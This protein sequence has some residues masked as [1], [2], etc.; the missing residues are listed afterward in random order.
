MV[1][2]YGRGREFLELDLCT[3]VFSTEE[4][5]VQTC[6]HADCTLFH[7]AANRVRLSGADLESVHE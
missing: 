5:I 7:L 6:A 3:A 4:W 2:T 1:S